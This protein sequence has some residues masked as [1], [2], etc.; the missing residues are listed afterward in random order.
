MI[1]L[2]HLLLFSSLSFGHGQGFKP[3]SPWTLWCEKH[4]IGYDTSDVTDA[5]WSMTRSTFEYLEQIE[6]A[7]KVAGAK[8]FL[9]KRRDRYDVHLLRGLGNELRRFNAGARALDRYSY[10]EKD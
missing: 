9:E 7:Y 8:V 4:L 5:Y 6:T 10:L 3:P 2:I 1:T